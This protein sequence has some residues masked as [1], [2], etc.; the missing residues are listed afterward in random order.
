[1]K[2]THQH[3][4]PRPSPPETV[5]SPKADNP[6]FE[7]QPTPQ[8]PSPKPNKRHPPRPPP[9]IKPDPL[10]HEPGPLL[11]PKTPIPQLEPI[12]HP[13]PLI[14][15]QRAVGRE[16]AVAGDVGGEGVRAHGVADGAGAGV[17]VFC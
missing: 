7:E 16:H 13:L 3:F 17:Q 14:P 15:A 8:T 10:T 11:T 2:H 4:G 6:I 12:N 1:M 5:R 9:F